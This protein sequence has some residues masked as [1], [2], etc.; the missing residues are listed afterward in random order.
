MSPLP[1]EVH[2][3]SL[4]LVFLMNSRGER[5]MGQKCPVCAKICRGLLGYFAHSAT[6]CVRFAPCKQFT[7]MSERKVGP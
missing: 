3:I 6:S 7:I 4:T 2:S 1:C 5:C